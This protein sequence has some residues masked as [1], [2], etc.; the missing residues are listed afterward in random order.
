MG[1]KT[2]GDGD[3][4]I[5]DINVTPLVDV[6][7]VLLIIFMVTATFI[8][9]PV[10]KVELPKAASEDRLQEDKPTLSIYLSKTNELAL[11]GVMKDFTDND[12]LLIQPAELD[13]WLARIYAKHPDIQVAIQ[14][15]KEVPYGKI[16]GLI[17]HIKRAGISNFAFNV[18][19]GAMDLLTDPVPAANS[20]A[21]ET[22]P[23][24][25][26]PDSGTP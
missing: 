8:V 2:S 10:V 15:D 25:T 13:S 12:S 9:T 26:Q 6:M 20:P 1:V 17:D 19:P 24:P 4:G 16:M 7:L 22:P 18:D 11:A 23:A 21:G 14:G 3:E 5:F